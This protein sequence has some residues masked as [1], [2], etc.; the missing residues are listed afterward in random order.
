M[1]TD[2]LILGAGPAGL[3]AAI[4]AGRSGYSTTLLTG[5]EEGGKLSLTNTI[6]NYPGFENISGY[7]LTQNLKN[8]AIKA[9]VQIKN[10]TAISVNIKTYPFEIKTEKELYHTKSLII[11]TGSVVNWLNLK[12]EARFKGKGIS[13]CAI[14]DGFFYKNK[15]VAVIGGGNTAMYEAIHLSKTSKKVFIISNQASLKGE[16]ALK[17]KIETINNIHLISNATVME[18][19]GQTKLTHLKIKIK[20]Q[21]QPFLLAVDGCFEAVGFSPASQLFEN[22]LAI[23][24]T[25]YIQTNC[26]SYQTSIEG[27]FACGDIQESKNRQAII[28]CGSGAKA[29]LSAIEYLEQKSYPKTSLLY[30]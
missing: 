15:T 8:Q 11:A 20:G 19:V 2:I 16:F 21:E 4:Y 6:E 26:T 1:Q 28:A 5:P 24:N 27:I 17:Q 7:Q 25:G 22:Q 10:E 14:C 3:S 30:K 9:Q 23:S 12:S 29:A 13:V 18:F